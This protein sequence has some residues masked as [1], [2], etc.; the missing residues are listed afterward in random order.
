VHIEEIRKYL[1][2]PD[3][4]LP[5][6][7]VIAFDHRVRFVANGDE[8]S[9]HAR[10]GTLEIPIR[11]G[12][13]DAEKPG[14]IVDG[15]QR[16]VAI[17]DAELESFPLCAT[18]FIA[19]DEKE[20]R[21]QFMLVNSTKPLSKSLLL[22][23]LPETEVK[24]PAQL[25]RYKFPA[26]LLRRLNFDADSPLRGKVRTETNPLGIVQDLGLLNMLGNSLRDGVLYWYRDLLSGD[27]DMESMIGV[28]K[29]FWSAVA[30]AFPEAWDLPPQKSRLTHGAGVIGMGRLMDTISNRYRDAGVPKE[31]MFRQD[32]LPLRQVCRWTEGYWE[33][34]P[35]DRRKW[36]ELQNTSRDILTLSRFLIVNYRTLVWSCG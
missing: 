14:L 32:L 28:L 23:L 20:Q 4:L 29:N 12:Q 35:G 5:N 6:A 21:E 17:R 36:N 18:G 8:C 30:C 27:T 13:S 31:E 1:E 10:F 2:S 24:L 7:I 16:S 33:F 19:A 25:H 34:G 15:Q 26:I 3:P 9:S 11:H 22:E